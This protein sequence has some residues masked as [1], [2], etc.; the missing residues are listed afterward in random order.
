MVRADLR[1]QKTGLSRRPVAPSPR[2]TPGALTVTCGG[3]CGLTVAPGPL[4]P[5]SS[6]WLYPSYCCSPGG[7]QSTTPG[8][9]HG[10]CQ[11]LTSTVS[12]DWRQGT[13]PPCLH[14]PGVG[15]AWVLGP[16]HNQGDSFSGFT[17][18]PTVHSPGKAAG[19]RSQRHPCWN[20]GGT[21]NHLS[22]LFLLLF[23][24]YCVFVFNTR[25]SGLLS[26][27]RSS[28]LS[29]TTSICGTLGWDGPCRT[30]VSGRQ[31]CVRVSPISLRWVGLATHLQAPRAPSRLHRHREGLRGHFYGMHLTESTTWA[32]R[33]DQSGKT[34]QTTLP[35]WLSVDRGQAPTAFIPPAQLCGL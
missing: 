1:K 7:R 25:S 16:P 15:K 8:P 31:G 5:S 26:H 29:L 9:L 33:V 6:C 20:Y 28:D 14:G 2:T 3:L 19:L 12:P 22:C 30:H 18:L 17:P 32:S 21:W 4:P 27:Q 34:S 10:P 11:G 13:G 24:L 35:C 23:F